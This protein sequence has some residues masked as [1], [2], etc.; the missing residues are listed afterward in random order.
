MDDY[1]MV[2][3]GEWFCSSIGEWK[4]EICNQLFSRVVPIH[5]GITLVALNEAILQEFGVKGLNPL[6]SYFV[7]NKNMFATKDKTPPV[8]VTSEF[9]LQ[10]Y[11]NTL[12]ENRGL[13]L[14]VKFEEKVDTPNLSYETPGSSA[15]RKVESLYDT[16]SG[17]R[18]ADTGSGDISS[19]V[20]KSPNVLVTPVD[21][22]FMDA[23]HDAEEKIARSGGL[24]SN[25]EVIVNDEDDIFVDDLFVDNKTEETEDGIDISYDTMPCGGYDKEFWGNFL[26]DDYGGSNAEELMSKGGVDARYK[27]KNNKDESFED[28]ND[29]VGTSEDKVVQYTG[30]GVFDHAVF[31]SGGG[32]GVNAEKVKTEWA[33]KT[34][35]GCKAGSSHGLRGGA[36]KLKEIDDEEFDIPPL[37]E[38][39]E[40]EVE[41][42]PDLDI[43]DDGKGIYKGK[44]YASKEDCQIYAIKN[45]FHFKQTRT[46]W[47]YFVLSCSDE[48][49]D[50]RILATLMKGTGYYEIK[51]ASLDHTCSLDTRGPFMQKATSKVIASVFKAKYSDPT[52]GPVPMD[53]QQLVLED[54]RVSADTQECRRK[55]TSR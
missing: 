30:S 38:D 6:L 1:I 7:P 31:V 42:I 33:A 44:V 32:S 28:L 14:F 29:K 40:Y 47:N 9:G 23:L 55:G 51:K 27:G 10:Y 54:L 37:F 15:K 45:M 12:R 8:L 52:S 18:N 48:K 26:S 53:L 49:C 50:Y 34:K 20:S 36:R 11:L 43:E 3:C 16:T 46:K 13:N 5:E 4:L 22:E 25:E 41:N 39:I 21:D 2:I 24:K 17:S 19:G 35:V